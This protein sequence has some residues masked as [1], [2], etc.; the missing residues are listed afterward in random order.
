M[1]P[2]IEVLGVHPVEADEP[3][4][5]VELVVHDSDGQF[6][7]GSFTQEIADEPQD[8]WQM[9]WDEVVLD[10]DGGSVVS[11]D[12][13]SGDVRIAFFF[14]YLDKNRPLVTPFGDVDL[15]GETPRPDRLAF[16]DYEPP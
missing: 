9:P 5:L 4:H 16:L 12:S 14:H 2:R 10:S 8:N 6:D 3:C 15:P 11:G 7:I 13:P 1:A